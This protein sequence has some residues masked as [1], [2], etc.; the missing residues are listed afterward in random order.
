LIRTLFRFLKQSDRIDQAWGV[1]RVL[2]VYPHRL[3][4]LIGWRI[5]RRLHVPLVLFMRDLCAESLTFR[6]PVRRRFWTAVDRTCL[7]DAWMILVPTAEFADH[8]K[9]R[10]IDRCWVLPHSVPVNVTPTKPAAS[11]DT[12]HLIYSGALYDAHADAA[13]AFVSATKRLDCVRITYLT[14]PNVYNGMLEGLGARWLPHREA[15]DALHQAD[16]FVLFLGKNTPFPAEI[17]GCFPSK[18][19]DYLSIGRP[20]LAIVPPG[21]FVDR[22]LSQTGCGIVVRQHD[23]QSIR[24]GIKQLADAGRR[25]RMAK[26]AARV[27]QGLRSEQW[28]SRLLARLRAGPFE[29]SRRTS[30]PGF[31]QADLCK[32]AA[33]EQSFSEEESVARATSRSEA[34]WNLSESVTEVPT[35]PALE[36]R[37]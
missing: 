34:F 2:A 10:G 9:T 12:L 21:C 17:Q 27:I 37:M 4:M 25:E 28:M 22:F 8:Y 36:A 15:M 33:A 31:M 19:I 32:Q 18:L 30:M 26:A 6:N 16:A 13:R 24:A 29:R 14:Q 20:I 7:S 23:E 1:E 11:G 3:S 35:E 5:A